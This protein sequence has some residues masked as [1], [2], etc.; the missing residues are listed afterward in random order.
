[1]KQLYAMYV[2]IGVVVAS[3]LAV[4][5]SAEGFGYLANKRALEARMTS[6]SGMDVG[7]MTTAMTPP[8]GATA[9]CVGPLL[10]VYSLLPTPPPD[11]VSYELAHPATNECSYSVPDSLTAEY[12]SYGTVVSAWY[13]SHEADLSSALSRCSAVA[14]SLVSLAAAVSCVTGGL[15]NNNMQATTATATATTPVTT[16]LGDD[17]VVPGMNGTTAATPTSEIITP[18]SLAAE[19]EAGIVGVV[20]AVFL[21][22]VLAL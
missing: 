16:G 1:M 13:Q 12:K 3:L 11:L 15:G 9:S 22:F 6:M 10:S 5:A 14:P 19:V 4:R 7:S 17:H 20:L 2:I 18:S 8:D 21:G